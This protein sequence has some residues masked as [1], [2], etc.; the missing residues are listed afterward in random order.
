V[1]IWFYPI[2]WE[3]TGTWMQAWAG[4]AGAG[5]V[6]WAT[7]FGLSTFAKQR[8]IE[9]R[10]AAAERIMTF[11]YKAKRAFPSIR[12]AGSF[13]YEHEAAKEKLRASFQGFDA[14]PDWKQKR[15]SI[16]QVT[17]DRLGAAKDLW[18]ELFEC[19]PLAR[20][21]FGSSCEEKVHAV[22]ELRARVSTSAQTYGTLDPSGNEKLNSRCE[23]DIWEG[24][25][26]EDSQSVTKG[27]AEVVT[28]MESSVLPHIA[29]KAV[30]TPNFSP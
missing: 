16:G 9:R 3:V 13:G 24:W 29:G 28:Y 30:P 2:D 15:L 12:N 8:Q 14:L 21:F 17:L 27:L 20:A 7:Y 11:T 26:D 1:T 25:A 5:A 23:A 6:V 10:I 22:W 19:L 18:A 4:F